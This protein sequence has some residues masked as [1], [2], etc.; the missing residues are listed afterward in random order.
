[1]ATNLGSN[2]MFKFTVKYLVV[3]EPKGSVYKEEWLD[4][5]TVVVYSANKT[6][7]FNKIKGVLGEAGAYSKFLFKVLLI[8]EV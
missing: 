4:A 6:D 7:V 3:P 8:E 2:N 1:M 5:V